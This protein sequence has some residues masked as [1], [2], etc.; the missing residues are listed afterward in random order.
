[1]GRQSLLE[2][3]HL[4]LWRSAETPG[5]RYLARSVSY[6]EAMYRELVDEGYIVKVVHAATDTEYEMR[7]GTLL[8][9]NS[10]VTA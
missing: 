4:Y 7:E 5:I 2:S 1:V 8:P 3:F 9:V 6:A 10:P